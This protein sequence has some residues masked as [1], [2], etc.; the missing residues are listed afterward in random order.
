MKFWEYGQEFKGIFSD[1][2]HEIPLCLSLHPL[3]I[4]VAIGFSEGIRV[5]Y[6][7]DDVL[8]IGRYDNAKDCTAIAYSDGGNLLAASNNTNNNNHFDIH[9]YNS[10]TFE[11]VMELNGHTSPLKEL[12][13]SCNDTMLISSCTQGLL[14][15]WV[16]S[17]KEKDPL[18]EHACSKQYRYLLIILQP[19]SPYI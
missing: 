19:P 12:L 11:K 13:W 1:Y 18:V 14:F 10:Y 7:L 6:I 2:F 8:R 3:S 17:N 5:Y 15:C 9:I 16:L 4:Q